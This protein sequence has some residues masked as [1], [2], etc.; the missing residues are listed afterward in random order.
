MASFWPPFGIFYF[1]I[2]MSSFIR[3]WER[4]GKTPRL[5][6]ILRKVHETLMMLK[7]SEIFFLAEGGRYISWQYPL[8]LNHSLKDK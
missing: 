1:E 7:N 2:K 3:F 4:A 6:V 8:D 5:T